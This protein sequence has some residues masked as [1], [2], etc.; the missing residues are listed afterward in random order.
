MD[1]SSKQVTTHTHTTKAREGG[2]TLEYTWSRFNNGGVLRCNVARICGPRS[3]PRQGWYWFGGRCGGRTLGWQVVYGLLL[4]FLTLVAQ[5]LGTAGLRPYKAKCELNY[6]VMYVCIYVKLAKILYSPQPCIG[7]FGSGLIWLSLLVQ[8][9]V[10]DRHAS[11][12]WL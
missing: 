1:K 2:C 10:V 7:Y 9:V 5:G 11:L 6:I 8:A 12:H 4:I 3:V